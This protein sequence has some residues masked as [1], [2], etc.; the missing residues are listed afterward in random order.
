MKN[1]KG[2]HI[3]IILSLMLFVIIILFVIFMVEPSIKKDR[4]K[5]YL[6][7]YLKTKLIKETSASLTSY[8]VEVDEN[9]ECIV[10][11]NPANGTNL[12][13]DIKISTFYNE[14]SGEDYRNMLIINSEEKEFNIYY[15]KVFDE[16][17]EENQHPIKDLGCLKLD[18]DLSSGKT[19]NYVYEEKV[20][21]LIGKD[22]S[23][24][25]NYFGVLKDDEFYFEFN[26]DDDYKL[27]DNLLE[28]VSDGTS[29][30]SE[31][32]PVVFFD[33]DAN[34]KYGFLT[35]KVW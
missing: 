18:N 35:V 30:F 7:D 31:Q 3:G 15:S 24:L 32:I 1:R 26:S 5:Q 17:S 16:I 28:D 23:E 12:L 22:Y 25:K 27:G 2:S 19:K 9:F 20:E 4:D 29:I 10:M 14:T 34:I 6:I 21:E 33:S 11:N 13:R 8:N